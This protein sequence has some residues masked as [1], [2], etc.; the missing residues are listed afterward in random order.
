[1]SVKNKEKLD[2]CSFCGK[3]FREIKLCEPC[4]KQRDQPNAVHHGKKTPKGKCQ[5][6]LEELPTVKLWNDKY[7][8]KDCQKWN[9]EG[10]KLGI[11]NH[12]PRFWKSWCGGWEEKEKGCGE[13]TCGSCSVRK[14]T[15][16]I[17]TRDLMIEIMTRPNFN[18]LLSWEDDSFKHRF[19]EVMWE[20]TQ[21]ENLTPKQI[22]KL[23]NKDVF[24]KK[25]S[26]RKFSRGI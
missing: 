12:C 1:M 24:E 3:E 18:A 11:G 6:C 7:Y 23:V 8:C 10:E 22:E 13:K 17:P 16:N 21:V 14:K 2:T 5:Q 4:K 15:L 26:Q 25:I 19:E 9:E 20:L